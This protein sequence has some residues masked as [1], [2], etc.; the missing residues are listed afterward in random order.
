[1]IF[2]FVSGGWMLLLGSGMAIIGFCLLWFSPYTGILIM[3]IGLGIV[4]AQE[5][6]KVKKKNEKKLYEEENEREFNRLKYEDPLSPQLFEL[7]TLLYGTIKPH[8]VWLREKLDNL[9][10][11][12]STDAMATVKETQD[13][14]NGK[15][16]NLFVSAEKYE[17]ICIFLSRECSLEIQDDINKMQKSGHFSDLN[18]AD[19]LEVMP[20]LN[21]L[22][23]DYDLEEWAKNTIKNEIESE[24]DRNAIINNVILQAKKELNK[25]IS[26]SC[27][28]NEWII[29]G[30][31]RFKI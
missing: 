14:D 17:K 1:M 25:S 28:H 23:A 13:I 20:D 27:L 10:V 4:W 16:K 9:E 30:R 6:Q 7:S 19:E 29:N 12:Y 3:V 21:D 24:T 15:F 31:I 8:E 2:K 18:K 26:V 5:D 11:M 22:L